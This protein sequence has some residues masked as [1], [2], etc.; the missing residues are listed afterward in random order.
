MD[1]ANDAVLIGLDRFGNGIA[2]ILRANHYQ[3]HGIDFNPDLVHY[4]DVEDPEFIGTLPLSHIKWVISTANV[5][6]SA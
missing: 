3:V 6:L 5:H 4:G 2:K 1:S